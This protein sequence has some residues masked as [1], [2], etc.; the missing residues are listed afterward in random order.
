MKRIILCLLTSLLIL[1]ACNQAQSSNNELELKDS[2]KGNQTV[3]AKVNGADI[4]ET[5]L[6]S[7]SKLRAE[8]ELSDLPLE[9]Q[10]QL[11][12]E[13]IQL[14]AL[15]RKALSLD[16]HNS[17]DYVMQLQNVK[18]NLLAQ[19]LLKQYEK[20]NPVSDAD[21][22]A[23]YDK[24][25]LEFEVPQLKASH[26]L[27]KTEE[28]ALAVIEQLK[29]QANFAEL[30][31]ELS[32]DALAAGGGELDWFSPTEML[33]PFAD[34]VIELEDGTFTETP[35]QTQYGYHIIKKEGERIGE[36][37]PLENLRP[38]LEQEIKQD[39]LGA[40]LES[41]RNELTIEEFFEPQESDIT[42]E[43]ESELEVK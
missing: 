40:Y 16:L 4:Y 19:A 33:A 2:F 6:T 12:D 14:E 32:T 31:K 30:A 7:Y 13:F 41:I 18:K 23:E 11:F 39:R 15:S 1:S 35:V 28:E 38:R 24:A 43:S 20:N 17:S 37:P 3:V 29:K 9:S 25:K 8:Q 22:Q 42:V 5:E 21:I 34:A 26:I 10:L 27:V 36:T